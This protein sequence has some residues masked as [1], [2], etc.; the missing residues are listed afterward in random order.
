MRRL[1]ILC[2]TGLLV[3]AGPLSAQPIPDPARFIPAQTELLVKIEQPRLLVESITSLEPLRKLYEL[4]PLQEFADSTTARRF[5]QLIDYYERELGAPW[6]ELLDGLAGGGAALGV[7]Y[8]PG[9]NNSAV[10]AIQGTD[11]VIVERFHQ[12]A[13]DLIN[14][15]LARLGETTRLE[16][17]TYQGFE[18]FRAGNFYIG[19]IGAAT[20]LASSKEAIQAVI[21]RELAR[22]RGETVASAAD[23][24][25]PKAAREL[26]PPDCLAWLWFGL[27]T[28]KGTP[29]GMQ[30]FAQP[31]DDVILTFLFGGILDAIRRADFVAAGINRTDEGFSLSVRLPS[32]RADLPEELTMH[33]PP[34]GEPGTLPL[35]EPKGVLFSHS[36]YLDVNAMWEHRDLL[37][38][39][40]NA[41]GFQEAV[42]QANKVLPGGG[43]D[44]LF[45]QGGAYHRFVVARPIGAEYQTQPYQPSPSAAYVISMRDPA[46]G[47][48]VEA[49]ARFG[50]FAASTQFGIK[51]NELKHD[52]II[53]VSYRFSE[54][55]D[56]LEDTER[57]RFNYDPCFAIVAEQM[58]FASNVQLCRELIDEIKAGERVPGPQN[59]RMRVYANGAKVFLNAVPDQLVT[60]AVLDQAIPV[61][62][63]QEQAEQ[64]LGL[65]EELG[66]LTFQTEHGPEFFEFQFAWRLGK[67]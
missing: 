66:T 46:F 41:E 9:G 43:L 67:E 34:I 64:L 59:M 56:I 38:T 37:F 65:L 55:Q 32:A 42:A 31:R 53:I 54:E 51:M 63:A 47:Q 26:L 14:S 44:D 3:L 27:D 19:R 13:F 20:V 39:P 15:E 22:G 36:F 7:E 29:Q 17:G 57:L 6:P 62:E 18:G 61:G 48:R 10:A 2:W 49:L 30:V 25:G 4:E 8:G 16:R 21:D 5:Y 12:L 35:L 11:E 52:D 33:V 23:A 24:E 45:A 40:Q 50:A 1:A 60:Q 28:V 58:I